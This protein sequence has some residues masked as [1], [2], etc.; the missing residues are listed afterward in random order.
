MTRATVNELQ[1]EGNLRLTGATDADAILEV[2]LVAL[3]QEPIRYDPK[4]PSRSREYRL[5]LKAEIVFRRRTTSE[6][7]VRKPVVARATFEASGD[8]A[9]P[10]R[11]A[12]PGLGANLAHGVVESIVEY[13]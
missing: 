2:T 5:N 6:V 9:G 7:I 1:K 3:E 12:M 13:W 8:L 10:K 11:E 4:E